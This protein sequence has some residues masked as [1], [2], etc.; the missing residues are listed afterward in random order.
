MMNTEPFILNNLS[1]SFGGLK[2]VSNFSLKMDP[3]SLWG[4]IGPNGAGKTTVFNLITGVYPAD[5]GEMTLG[6]RPLRN[7]KPF[8]ITKQGIARTFQ[9]IRLFADLTVLQNVLVAYHM[10]V[11]YGYV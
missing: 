7:L 3:N 11:P 8:Q 6:T 5:S 1:I 10:H 4:L 9:N 2:A